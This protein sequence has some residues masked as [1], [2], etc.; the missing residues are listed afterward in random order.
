MIAFVQFDSASVAL[1]EQLADEGRLPVLAELR[2]RGRWQPLEAPDAELAASVYHSLYSGLDAGDHGLYQAFQWRPAEQR[3]RFIN[4]ITKPETV[5]ERVSRAGGKVLA[6]DP[7]VHWPPS[8]LNGVAL[9]GWQFS[10]RMI[11]Q[12]WSRPASEL[13]RLSRSFGRPP[14][15]EE[16]LGQS[17]VQRLLALTR[18][19]EAAPARAAA[20]VEDLLGRE[21]FDLVWVTLAPAHFAGHWLW[22]PARL[23]E[24]RLDAATR[25]ELERALP[26][27]YAAV[28]AAVGR[29]LAALP[30]GADTIVLSPTG[31]GV[32][33][34]R[35]DLLP[36]MVRAVLD[37][38]AAAAANGTRASALWRV[39]GAVPAS[40]RNAFSQ[41]MPA[42]VNRELLSRLHLRGI[43][44]STTRAFVLPG[45]TS[46]L[47]RVNLQ[48][49]E[50]DGI[51]DPAGAG[52]LLDE[53][54]AGLAT[55]ADPD[56]SPAVSGF[57]RP[58][59]LWPGGK[60]VDDLPDLVVHWSDRPSHGIGRLTSPRFGEVSRAGVGTGWPGNHRDEAWALLLPA[61]ARV[62]EPGRPPQLVDLAATACTL[63]GAD[64][65]GLAGEPLLAR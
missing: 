4:R 61:S 8:T 53:L 25:G 26:A 33:T 63:T 27:I 65:T 43:D 17:S 60:W 52:A 58:A 6:V 45:D 51:V 19:L 50:R 62:R 40:A 23:F 64:A 35:G 15:L 10:N 44:W 34:S 5:W 21:H 37:G 11:L 57:D 41:A 20:A 14:R 55:F 48:G 29:I 46:G 28:D 49:R 30:P 16:T 59:E 22:D 42:A 47:V 9:S 38:R 13:P 54:E 56:G 7:F 39:R 3:I 18:N 32:N 24:G 1:L 36:A 2:A 31:I 12:R